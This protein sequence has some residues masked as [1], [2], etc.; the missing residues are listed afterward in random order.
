[1]ESS[2]SRRSHRGL[3]GPNII[4]PGSFITS[5]PKS[6]SSSQR[7][8]GLPPIR[9]IPNEKEKSVKNIVV[10]K[11]ITNKD[12]NKSITNP[13]YIGPGVW[14]DMHILGKNAIAPASKKLFI[15]YMNVL[16]KTFS[17]MEC[18]THII[19]YMKINPFKPY[20]TVKNE[21][22]VEVGLFKW[23]WLFHNV[24]NRRIRHPE[25]SWE[26]AYSLYYSDEGVC[27]S[28]CTGYS[29]EHETEESEHVNEDL[30][31]DFSSK[32]DEKNM[33][34]RLETI[35]VDDKN[36]KSKLTHYEFVPNR[37]RL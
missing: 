19:A 23:S 24:V 6:V 12:I 21:E 26:K 3:I 31:E 10:N 34:K 22:G 20:L 7:S 9:P 28:N 16:A 18:R 1:M 32:S 15:D 5:S 2:S 29:N 30:E 35:E 17:C 14:Y 37:E 36:H 33:R 4:K 27:M 25:V 13:K 11:T 8:V